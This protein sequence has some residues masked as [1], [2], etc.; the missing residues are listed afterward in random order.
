MG[1]AR[2]ISVTKEDLLAVLQKLDEVRIFEIINQADAD[3]DSMQNGPNWL[4]GI[5]FLA[6]RFRVQRGLKIW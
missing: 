3:N 6:E 1:T 5:V 4:T 2:E